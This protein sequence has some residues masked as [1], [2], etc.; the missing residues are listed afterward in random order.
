MICRPGPAF[1]RYVLVLNVLSHFSG[2]AKHRTG[3]ACSLSGLAQSSYGSET[4]QGL[5]P[6]F[7]QLAVRLLALESFNIPS[8]KP[9]D[10]GTRSVCGVPVERLG[11]S[12]Y[13]SKEK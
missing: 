12:S 13:K 2:I 10:V 7:E 6:S 4:Q 3:S 11:M 9:F 8:A 1:A 5:T